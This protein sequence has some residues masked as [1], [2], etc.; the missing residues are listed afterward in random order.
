[1]NAEDSTKIM[2]PDVSGAIENMRAA[3]S[4]EAAGTRRA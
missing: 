2:L 4:L 1:V 3:R